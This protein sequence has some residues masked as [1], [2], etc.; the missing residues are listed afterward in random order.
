MGYR[1]KLEEQDE[2]RRLRATGM[3]MPDIASRLGVSRSSVSLWTRDVPVERAPR[4]LATTSGPNR[5]QR[6]KEAEVA[7]L[8]AEGR[9]RIATL[10]DRDLLIAGTMLYAGE[11]CKTPGA[12]T[13]VNSDPRLIALHL[14][15]LRSCF[16]IDEGRL[17]V[18]LY[19]HDG[20]DLDRAVTFWTEVTGIPVGQFTKPHRAVADAGIRHNKHPYGCATVRYSCSRTHRAVMGLIDALLP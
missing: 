7:H 6:A 5:L 14:S 8:R 20:L 3:T 16:E 17:R 18:R 15:W 11:G 4:R 9:R 12:V 1:G 19:L 2:A 13:L 10:S